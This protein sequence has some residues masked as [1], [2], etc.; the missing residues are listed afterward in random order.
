MLF[1]T[2][3]LLALITACVIE[4]PVLFGLTRIVFR[5]KKISRTRIM[6]TGILCTA[7]TLPYL[8]FVIPSYVNA[9]YYPVIGEAFV[10][11]TEAIILNRV[12]DLNPKVA[13]LCSIIMN[14]TSYFLGLFLL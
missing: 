10:I 7:L 6:F 13:A 12:L 8:W 4:I 14:T 11:I 2:Q 3:F 1:Q 5:D 9:A